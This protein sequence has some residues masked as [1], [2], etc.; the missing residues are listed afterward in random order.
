MAYIQRETLHSGTGTGATGAREEQA[1]GFDVDVVVVGAGLAGLTAAAFAARAG[2]GVVVLERAA[3]VGGRAATHEDD[4]FLFNVGP[5]ALYDGGHAA[6][7][8]A[9]LGVRYS[10][11]RPPASGGL[12]YHGGGLHALPAGFVSLLTTNLLSLSGKLE[13]GRVLGS[14]GKIDAAALEGQT[15][16]RW[17][18]MT[19]RDGVVRGLVEALMRVTAYAN[20]P[21]RSCA[22]ASV[23]QLQAGLGRGVLYLDGGWATLAG[24]LRSAAENAGAVVR[25]GQRVRSVRTHPAGADVV[26]GA[27]A[28]AGLEESVLRARVVV[29]AIPPGVAA[30][31]VEGAGRETLAG[32][33]RDATP[34]KAACLDLGLRELPDPRRLFV[35]GIDR[36]LYFSVHSATARLAPEGGAAIH[37]AKYLPSGEHDMK[38]AKATEAELEAFCDAVQPGWRSVV[39]ARRYLP[40]MVV[41]GALVEANRSRPGPEVAAVPSLLV[42][43]DW[44]GAEGMIADTAVASGRRAG[45]MAAAKVAEMAAAMAIGEG[46]T[47]VA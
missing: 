15:L 27:A 33:A 19:F 30:S 28:T 20:D 42:A 45:G 11:R 6:R 41:T 37:V 5:H 35:V 44:V 4:G 31:V 22:A 46:A 1:G 24:G 43:G 8:L 13:L 36:P 29:L 10:G 26:V 18:D 9:D 21:D 16:R 47:A 34:V 32:W 25:T 14:L 3:E 39:V 2:A 7:A 12:A 40:S 23:S 17:L 38:A